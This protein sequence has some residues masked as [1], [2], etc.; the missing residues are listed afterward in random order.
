MATVMP[1]VEE[2]LR[3]HDPAP[4]PP[5]ARGRGPTDREVQMRRRDARTPGL[6]GLPEHL[7]GPHRHP[8][9]NPTL[10]RRQMRPVVPD[11][12]HAHHRHGKPAPIRAHIGRRIPPVHPCH[13]V[14]PPVNRRHE[15]AP[16][17]RE[18]IR[19]RIIMMTL[20][21]IR[22]TPGDR[23]HVPS[24]TPG[25]LNRHCPTPRRPGSRRR[26][27]RRRCRSLRRCHHPRRR[28]HRSARG[29]GL[30]A[31]DVRATGDRDDCRSHERDHP[32][33]THRHSVRRRS[34]A[35]WSSRSSRPPAP[36]SSRSNS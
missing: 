1:A 7:P 15:P 35:A 20:R 6:T 10:D 33:R 29:A 5:P 2:R 11:P 8:R 18:H 22:S 9:T 31:L 32:G 26:R 3:W 34:T 17:L 27:C 30:D 14:N 24:P 16:H 4:N 36:S 13:L 19:R 28:D 21:S 12:V 25:R 23:K